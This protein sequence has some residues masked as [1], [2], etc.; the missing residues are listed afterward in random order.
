MNDRGQ[1]AFQ[2]TLGTGEQGI[3][4]ATP[5]DPAAVGNGNFNNGLNLFQRTGN[6]DAY[7][8]TVAGDSVLQMSTDTT[9]TGILQLVRTSQT[10]YLLQF[11]FDWLTTA[12]SLDVTANGQQVLRLDPTGVISSLGTPTLVTIGD[13]TRLSL[14]F[15]PATFDPSSSYIEFDLNP[16]PLAE[17]RLD[18]LTFRPVPEPSAPVLL[19]FA[20]AGWCL[21]RCRAA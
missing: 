16:G 1:V 8:V 14:M 19:M 20:T 3:A 10:E 15:N 4:L 7:V 11:D 17:I 5:R 18:N 12:G 13:F 9:P 2:Y 21:R 6:Q